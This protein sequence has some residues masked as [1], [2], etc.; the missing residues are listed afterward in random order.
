MQKTKIQNIET[1]VTKNCDILKKNDQFLEVVLEGTTIKI[2]L[3]KQRD[4]YIGKFKDMEF[5]STGN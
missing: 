5:V 4:K 2:L 3:K 1:G